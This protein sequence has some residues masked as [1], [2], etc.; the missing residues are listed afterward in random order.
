MRF[1][2]TQCFFKSF[3]QALALQPRSGPGRYGGITAE[4]QI[5][6]DLRALEKETEGL[7]GEI[8]KGSA[9]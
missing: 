1:M 8:V 4:D 5:R 6:A 9:P 3:F 7:L 2:A